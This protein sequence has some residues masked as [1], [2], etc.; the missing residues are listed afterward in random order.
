MGVEG[1][2]DRV[3]VGPVLVVTEAAG[4]FSAGSAQAARNR[5]RAIERLRSCLSDFIVIICFSR[6]M[7]WLTLGRKVG[8]RRPWRH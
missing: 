7:Q 6:N 3:P 2:E 8:L 4:T 1:D 5:G